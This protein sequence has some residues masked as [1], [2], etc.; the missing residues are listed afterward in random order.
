MSK[1]LTYIT[2]ALAG[3]A[4]GAAVALLAAPA[5]GEDTRRRIGQW[6]RDEQLPET[7]DPVRRFEAIDGLLY[8]PFADEVSE[9]AQVARG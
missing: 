8:D 5:P 3:G 4:V 9:L 7:A 2:L 6:F 1:G